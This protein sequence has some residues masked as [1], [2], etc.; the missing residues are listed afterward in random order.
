MRIPSFSHVQQLYFSRTC[1]MTLTLAGINSSFSLRDSPIWCSWLPQQSQDFSS[2]L[3]SWMITSR[4]RSFGSF[5][6]T[7]FFLTVVGVDSTSSSIISS[8]ASA[9]LNKSPC[10]GWLSLCTPKRYCWAKR[11]CSIRWCFSAVRFLT[12]DWRDS[13]ISC[14]ALGS[15]GKLLMSLVMWLFYQ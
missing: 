6:R 14:R 9:L 13:T 5:C 7:G 2:S 15:V 12:C 4:S 1:S 8:A 10:A 11:N 3:K